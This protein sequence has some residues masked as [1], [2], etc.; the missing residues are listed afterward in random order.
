[1]QQVTIQPPATPGGPVTVI[2]TPAGTP[3]SPQQ[4]HALILR[5]EELSGQLNL[6]KARKNELLNEIK[7]TSRNSKQY[8]AL[9]ERLGDVEGRIGRL[10]NEHNL[11]SDQIANAPA[12]AYPTQ[13]TTEVDPDIIAQ[14]VMDEI[15]PL[16]AIVSVF[17]FLP[18]TLLF[19]RLIWRRTSAPSQASLADQAVTAKR[20]EQI[21]QSIDTI[22]VEVER[23]SEGQ[24]YTAKM[25]DRAL[26]AGAADGTPAQ[27]K[28]AVPSYSSRP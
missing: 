27:Q 10:E 28:S 25:M 9:E 11:V 15:V 5:R 22:A 12:S 7:F 3:Q 21:Q 23:I 14:R 13:T 24:R 19:V 4:L 18:I 2:H 26:G 16:T 6:A 1:M 8:P 17:V 20:L